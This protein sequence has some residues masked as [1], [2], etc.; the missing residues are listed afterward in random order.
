MN[1][2]QSPQPPPPP[3][4]PPPISTCSLREFTTYV[5]RRKS[6]N[7]RL[8]ETSDQIDDR[9]LSIL[10]ELETIERKTDAYQKIVDAYQQF[11]E[12][13]R[14]IEEERQVLDAREGTLKRKRDAAV[15]DAREVF[16]NKLSKTNTWGR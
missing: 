12:G 11:E 15:R 14:A 10:K 8:L 3:P 2:N 9:V 4:P 5:E 6:T 16:P 7:K 1:A 13:M